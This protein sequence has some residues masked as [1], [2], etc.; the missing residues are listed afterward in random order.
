MLSNLTK[1]APYDIDCYFYLEL[2]YV[3]VAYS[4]QL[5]TVTLQA[6]SPAQN[7]GG[8]IYV[9]R[10]VSLSVLVVLKS[11]RVLLFSQNDLRRRLH[12]CDPL[13]EQAQLRKIVHL[14]ST[15]KSVGSLLR[16]WITFIYA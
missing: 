16:L 8:L 6:K 15:R 4:R 14:L 9:V 1:L 5:Q 10:K 3:P 7:E 11:L 2:E 12:C 13:R